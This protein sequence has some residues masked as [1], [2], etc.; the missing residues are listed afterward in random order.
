M[1]V[2]H[3]DGCGDDLGEERYKLESSLFPRVNVFCSEKCVIDHLQKRLQ[4]KEKKV[5]HD[6]DRALA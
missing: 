6:P 1:E 4:L 5:S 3:C 2:Y